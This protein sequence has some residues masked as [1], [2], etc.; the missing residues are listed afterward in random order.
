MELNISAAREEEIG[1]KSLPQEEKSLTC[2]VLTSAA[3]E[4]VISNTLIEPVKVSGEK[5]ALVSPADDIES[6]V[7]VKSTSLDVLS[8]GVSSGIDEADVSDTSPTGLIYPTVDAA[9]SSSSPEADITDSSGVA[10]EI[11]DEVDKGMPSHWLDAPRTSKTKI[12][13]RKCF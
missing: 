10:A 6:T 3:D 8:S 1:I 11:F 5:V 13:K 7:P 4:A 9:L 2:D 12:S